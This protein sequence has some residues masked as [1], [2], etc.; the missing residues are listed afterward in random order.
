MPAVIPDRP[1]A[2]VRAPV[3]GSRE[4]FSLIEAA[5]GAFVVGAPLQAADGTRTVLRALAGTGRAVGEAALLVNRGRGL[6]RR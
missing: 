2:L 1:E 6:Y 5:Q 3:T 4:E